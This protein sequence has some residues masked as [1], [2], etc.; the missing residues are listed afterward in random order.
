MG[1]FREALDTLVPAAAKAGTRMVAENMPFGFLPRADQMM[2]ALDDYGGDEVGVVYDVANAVFAR[3][4]PVEGLRL[5]RDRLELVHLSD[6]G[7]EAYR[8]DP[9]GRGVVDF[10][11]F[12]EGLTEVGYSGVAMLEVISDNADADI[13]DSADRLLAMAPWRSFL[14]CMT[15]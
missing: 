15:P 6:T 11:G 3:E 10:A 12:A 9:I 13:A 8:H 2:S 7:L 4:D 5:V 1:W 14:Q